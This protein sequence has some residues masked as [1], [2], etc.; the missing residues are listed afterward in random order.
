[1]TTRRRPNTKNGSYLEFFLAVVVVNVEGALVQVDPSHFSGVVTRLAP[2]AR[3]HHLWVVFV[4]VCVCVCV[5]VR[6]RARARVRVRLRVRVCKCVR[7]LSV[8][9][10]CS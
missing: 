3:F 2:V 8:S 5:C 7:N 9:S 1:M 10:F 4:C 6:A